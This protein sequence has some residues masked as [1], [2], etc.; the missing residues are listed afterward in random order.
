[1]KQKHLWISFI[2]FI[3]VCFFVEILGSFW[4]DETSL[5]WYH[6]IAKPSWNPPDW[7]FGPVWTILYIMIAISGWLIYR[8][9]HSTQRTVALIFYTLQLVSNFLWAFLFFSLHSPVLSLIDI[10]PLCIFIG[11]TIIKAWPV[12]KLASVLLIPY[13]FWVMYATSLNT[14]IWLLN[15]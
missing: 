2:A 6:S 11:L 13:F 7:V 14:A 9:E 3:L 1:M 15:G 8:A 4:A 12:S 5:R 10:V